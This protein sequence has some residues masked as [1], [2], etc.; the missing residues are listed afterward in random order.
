MITEQFQFY[1]ARSVKE[2]VDL[3]KQFDGDAKLLAGG[4]SLVPLMN[5]GLVAPACIIDITKILDLSY[6][7][8]DGDCVTIGALTPHHIIA[9]STL[10]QQNCAMLVDA[11]SHIGDLQV[12]HRGTIS[13]A[14]CHADP[15]GDYSPVLVAAGA[16]FQLTSSEGVRMAKAQDFFQDVFTTDLKPTEMLTSIRIPKPRG[17]SASSYQKLEFITGGFAIA[18]VAALLT[19]DGA[20]K[21]Q[22]LCVVIGAVETKPILLSGVEAE[23]VGKPLDEAAM[24]KA[25]NAASE[26]V[27]NPLSDIHADGDYRRAMAGVLTRRAL[28]AALGRLKP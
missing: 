24:A 17:R 3:L 2:S 13:G 26:A 27:T 16:E 4:Q 14:V 21:C 15:A 8:D 9:G 28:K 23:L 25:G 18:G 19:V 10:I 6:T 12:R 22:G 20:G 11:A 5:L 1:A 7:R